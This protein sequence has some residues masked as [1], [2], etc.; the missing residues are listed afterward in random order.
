MEG[1]LAEESR[2]RC[3]AEKG[4]AKEQEQ[5]HQAELSLRKTQSDSHSTNAAVIQSLR[6]E[7]KSQ[8]AEIAEAQKIKSR[9]QYVSGTVRI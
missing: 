1:K 8:E 6:S 2:L 4:L 9:V 5:R 7:L 3:S